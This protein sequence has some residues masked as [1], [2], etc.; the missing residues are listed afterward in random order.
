MKRTLFAFLL[1]SGMMTEA[2]TYTT[3]LKHVA[4]PA[5]VTMTFSGTY[6]TGDAI[7][8]ITVVGP[9]VAATLDKESLATSGWRIAA[10]SPVGYKTP[11]FKV[12]AYNWVTS[13]D[14]TD[15]AVEYTGTAN[16][17]YPDVA[18]GAHERGVYVSEITV[19][20]EKYTVT[21]DVNSANGQ[22]SPGSTTVTYDATYGA[23]TAGALPT[24]TRTGYGFDGWFTAADGGTQVT[25]ATVVKITSAQVLYAHWTPVSYKVSFVSNGGTGSMADQTL[26]YDAEAYLNAN[27]FT[28]EN[29]D[30]A[31]WAT[32]NLDVV[33][34]ADGAKVFNL[35]NAQD[36]VVTLKALWSGKIYTIYYHSNFIAEGATSEVTDSATFAYGE[37]CALHAALDRPDHEFL[38]WSKSS[39]ATAREYVAGQLVNA[40]TLPFEDGVVHLYAVWKADMFS[41]AF[42]ANGGDGGESMDNLSAAVAD[43]AN[44]ALPSNKF[45]NT[46]C[47]FAGWALNAAGTGA[48]FGNAE[49]ADL[50]SA[51]VKDETVTLHAQ[52]VPYKVTFVAEE[53][54]FDVAGSPVA[55]DTLSP[56]AQTATVSYTEGRPYSAF[57]VATNLNEVKIFKKWS[58][59]RDG[60]WL[61]V[62]EADIVLPLS[63]GVTNLVAQWG[64]NDPL[65]DA[66]DAPTL[67]FSTSNSYHDPNGVWTTSLDT[68]AKNGQAAFVHIANYSDETR[69]ASITASL[70]GP[71][72]LSF[73]WKIESEKVAMA[74]GRPD[75]INTCE[76]L[77]FG[78][79]T[80]ARDN[81]VVGLAADS[82]NWLVVSNSTGTL[83]VSGTG[84]LGWQ[85]NV[86]EITAASDEITS[87]TWEFQYEQN[88]SDPTSHGRAWIDNVQWTGASTVDVATY[89]IMFDANGGNGSMPDQTVAESGTA[90]NANVFEYAG[91]TFAGWNTQA[92]GSGVAFADRAH[93]VSAAEDL[94]LHA[95]WTANVYTVGFDPNGGSVA[96]NS[97]TVTFGAPYGELPTPTLE[98][99]GFDGWFTAADGGAQV[100][101][102]TAVATPSDH[103]LYAHW[104]PIP[105]TITFDS[106]GGSA[107]DAITQGYG[108]SVAAPANPTRDGYTF[109][110]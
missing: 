38:G 34:Y 3:P 96:P 30:F 6:S 11:K 109:V 23:G 76:R 92:D 88:G 78:V 90:L 20:A 40:T 81:L 36:A 100:T 93:D 24:P 68:T 108:T 83:S 15:E 98:G 53:G 77:L 46:G 51:A 26:W 32:N 14:Y 69:W 21:F 102:A 5:N 37:N 4:V 79:G 60:V 16:I 95:Q 8:D 101:A 104:T 72:T 18:H 86:I 43:A 58:Q 56:N 35:A 73:L 50:K 12:C 75:W 80:T 10:A 13:T 64:R 9:A 110:E 94:T 31:G 59:K 49:V 85:T 71:G 82:N 107:V 89:T 52:W 84:L 87:V 105:Y 42:D 97:T 66:L 7:P 91:Y 74:E 27:A 99:Y 25:D 17:S 28:K 62:D 67:E 22:V 44:V 1:L 29:Y 57:P 54:A 39:N 45:T 106:A 63:A 19:E 2:I 65:A 48:R 41:V 61:P 47:A 70:K 103:T 33:A 55:F